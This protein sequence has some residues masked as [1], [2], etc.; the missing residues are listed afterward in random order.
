M[1]DLLCD[2]VGVGRL[3]TAAAREAPEEL[4]VPLVE[5]APG[6]RVGCVREAREQTRVSGRLQGHTWS[7]VG[8][9][10]KRTQGKPR[11]APVRN[12]IGR[13]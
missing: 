7:L 12:A 9:G 1:E 13:P 4:A 3:E 10:P 6:A 11:C 5:L 8:A 2:V